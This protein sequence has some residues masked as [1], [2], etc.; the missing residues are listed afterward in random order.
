MANGKIDR[1]LQQLFRQSVKAVKL[2]ENASPGSAFPAQKISLGLAGYDSIMTIYRPSASGE[3]VKEGAGLKTA[4]T[5]VINIASASTVFFASRG[6]SAGGSG[7]EFKNT[8]GKTG[9]TGTPA[10]NAEMNR[11]CVPVKIY[12]VKFIEGPG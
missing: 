4:L 7:V 9:T 8:F 3:N 12:G 10:Q 6:V 5:A 1:A 11:Y 2:W